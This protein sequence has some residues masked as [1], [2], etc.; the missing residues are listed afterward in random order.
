VPKSVTTIPL[1]E[2]G[3]QENEEFSDFP[4]C[5][6]PVDLPFLRAIRRP[7][8]LDEP[9]L[10]GKWQCIYLTQAP[11]GITLFNGH[12]QLGFGAATAFPAVLEESP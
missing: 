2:N 4:V 6:I 3:S 11:A 10:L 12:P 9:V 5:H 8:L 7:P 1:Q